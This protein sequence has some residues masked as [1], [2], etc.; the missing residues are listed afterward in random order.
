MTAIA[1]HARSAVIYV[2]RADS[3]TLG[4][5]RRP[6]DNTVHIGHEAAA[7]WFSACEIALLRGRGCVTCPAMDSGSVLL[8]ARRHVDTCRISSAACRG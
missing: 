3:N 2:V 6:P 4:A 5:H 8:V 1:D 7:S